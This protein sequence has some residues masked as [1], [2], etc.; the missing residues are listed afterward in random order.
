MSANNNLSLFVPHVFPNFTRKYIAD[1]FAC[2][3][4]VDRVD[5]HSKQDRY[6]K[7]FNAAYIHFIRLHYNRASCVIQ[8]EIGKDG[9][10]KFYHDDSEYYWIVLPNTSK[11]YAS[12]N[13]KPRIDLGESNS[14]SVRALEKTPKPSKP[15]GELVAEFEEWYTNKVS[16]PM[17]EM[18][19]ELEAENYNLITI[20]G[21]YVKEI[22][23]ENMRMRAEISQLRASY[24]CYGYNFN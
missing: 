18:D 13:P 14:L 4:D 16:H 2:V 17:A 21:R 8:S 5:L 3:G 10:A 20:D 15:I 7:A 9:S 6:G 23:E 19:A 1:A 12:G 24:Y 22:E 11:K